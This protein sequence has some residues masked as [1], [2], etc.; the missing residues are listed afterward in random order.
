MFSDQADDNVV[1]GHLGSAT[2]ATAQRKPF[3]MRAA[4]LVSVRHPHN[5]DYNPTLWT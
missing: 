4:E 3:F 5:M 2:T 1:G